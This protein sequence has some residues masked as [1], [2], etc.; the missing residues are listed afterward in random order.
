VSW[1]VVWKGEAVLRRATTGPVVLEEAG[2]ALA[3]ALRRASIDVRVVRDIEPVLW[4]KL[5]FNLNNAINALSGLPLREE[6]S[7]RGWRSVV[8][9][10]QREGLA[11]MRAAGIR[12]VRL[13]RLDARVAARLLPAP[14]FVFR[15]LAGAMI[16]IDPAARS[17]M[18]DDLDRGRTTEVDW[19]NGAVVRL[20][21]RH[22]VPTPVNERVVDAIRA[23]ER[24]ERRAIAPS[25]LAR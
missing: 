1:N 11:A 8:A 13:G 6:L 17:S 15:L 22:G 24:G 4:T 16:R 23:R 7:Q 9:A 19:L 10:C 12:P 14:D 3:T 2:E 5:L 25:D 18:A 20:G 21:A